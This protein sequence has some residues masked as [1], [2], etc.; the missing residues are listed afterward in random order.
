MQIINNQK[1]TG[2]TLVEIIVA[3]SIFSLIIGS[4]YSLFASGIELV[5]DNQARVTALAVANQQVEIIKNLPYDDIGTDGGV[6]SGTLLQSQVITSNNIP[7]TVET[8]IRFV[9]DEY[10]NVSPTDLLPVDYKRVQ[11]DVSWPNMTA[12]KAVSLVTS[13]VPNGI[14]TDEGGGTL[15]IEV[16]DPSLETVAPVD[17]ATVTIN[18]S[19]TNPDVAVSALTD[20]DGRYILLGAPVGVEAYEVIVTKD[21]Y[22]TDRTYTRDS[23]TNPNPNPANLTV[24]ADQVTTEYFQISQLVDNLTI[25][26][27]EDSHKVTICHFSN[28]DSGNTISVD[29]SAMD[30]HLAHSDYTGP[31]E[32]GFDE[33]GVPVDTTFTMHGEKTIGTDSEGLPIYKFTD[34]FNT[35]SD[36]EY[37]ATNIETDIYHIVY[38]EETEGYVISGYSEAL[39]YVALP[40]TNQKITFELEDYEPYTLL[41]T[42]ENPDNER[43]TNASVRVYTDSLSYDYTE[44]AYQYGQIFLGDLTPQTYNIEITLTD[45]QTYTGTINVSG[46]EDQTITLNP[47]S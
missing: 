39:P 44:I 29:Y 41:L 7:F 31:C 5:R 16:Y 17:G 45:Y 24:L 6:P 15:W 20:T 32:G 38:D 35:G 30:S 13:I 26:M 40:N 18:A 46:N 12:N 8:D 2:N 36:G 42:V 25:R 33:T 19:T 28:G 43:L 47:S 37:A 10:D 14:E 27:Q 11:I 1:R 3:V 22:S 4:L 9:D 34:E 21:G 23:I